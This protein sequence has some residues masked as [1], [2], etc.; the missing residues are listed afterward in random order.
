MYDRQL[1]VPLFLPH[2]EKAAKRPSRS[3]WARPVA[4]ILRDAANAA[5]QDEGLTTSS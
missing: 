2:P 3:M 5:P 1:S 4:F